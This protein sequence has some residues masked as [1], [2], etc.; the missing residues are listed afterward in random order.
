VARRKCWALNRV[1]FDVATMEFPLR[2]SVGRCSF[3]ANGTFPS[4]PLADK[5]E[6]GRKLLFSAHGDYTTCARD[7]TCS[8]KK[9]HS[10]TLFGRQFVYGC[11]RALLDVTA[12]GESTRAP[13]RRFSNFGPCSK[14]WARNRDSPILTFPFRPLA[15]T[16]PVIARVPG[17]RPR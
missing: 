11:I 1:A 3:A 2:M 6:R 7:L 8:P 16:A 13:C 17:A 14:E 4:P 15:E 12:P 10:H 5:L 9:T